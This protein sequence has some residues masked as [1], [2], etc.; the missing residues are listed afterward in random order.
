MKKTYAYYHWRGV[1]WRFPISGNGDKFSNESG[2][3]SH[4][5][6]T[7]GDVKETAFP[8]S[9]TEAERLFPNSTK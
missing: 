5:T 9:E 2:V 7:E 3:W 1:L 6:A 4:A 8:V